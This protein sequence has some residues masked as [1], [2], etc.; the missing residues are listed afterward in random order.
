MKAPTY[1]RTLI[2]V[3]M[4]LILPVVAIAAD[5]EP[6]RIA[7][8]EKVDIEKYVVPGK[9]TVFDFTSEYCPPCVA[10][11]PLLHDLD[12]KRDDL[13]IVEVDINR[14]GVKG[15]D[16]SSPVTAQYGI[17]SVPSFKVYGPDGKLTAENEEAYEMVSAWLEEES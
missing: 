12:A 13:V 2:P 5:D 1:L 9:T 10:I 15:I 8:G 16:W 11:A 7:F 6:Q 4:A 3:A 14:E 17:Q